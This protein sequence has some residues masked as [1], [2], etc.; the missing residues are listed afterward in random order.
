MVAPTGSE[1][2]VGAVPAASMLLHVSAPGG[3]NLVII[4][5]PRSA[6]EPDRPTTNPC[7]KAEG[8]SIWN[9]AYGCA[10]SRKMEEG[11][12]EGE[13]EGDTEDEVRLKIKA[14]GEVDC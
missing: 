8:I 1:A 9:C 14:E 7:R 11:E 4:C 6:R 3:T 12:V 5:N 13:T 2:I 10:T